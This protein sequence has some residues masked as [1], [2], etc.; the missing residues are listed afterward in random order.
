MQLYNRCP[1]RKTTIYSFPS[2]NKE[3][4][5]PAADT[6]EQHGIYWLYQLR[7][8][9]R[10]YISSIA[11]SAADCLSYTT[12]TAPCHQHPC[13]LT[14]HFHPSIP[15]ADKTTNTAL[16][17]LNMTL[18]KTAGGIQQSYSV[19]SPRKKSFRPTLTCHLIQ[20]LDQRLPSC[21]G[22]RTCYSLWLPHLLPQSCYPAT[23]MDISSG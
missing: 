20:D 21:C 9:T 14:F 15:S 4:S 17:H 6:H 3:R 8:K 1:R 10:Q 22:Y 16:S 13:I 7:G 11:L 23:D 5:H 2:F 19:L 12:S 18:L